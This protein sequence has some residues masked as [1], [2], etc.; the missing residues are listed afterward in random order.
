MLYKSVFKILH[1]YQKKISQ[2]VTMQWIISMSSMTWIS[3]ERVEFTGYRIISLTI[4]SSLI[5][6]VEWA[7]FSY[8][9]MRL[10]WIK[11]TEENEKKIQIWQ[12]L[13]AFHVIQFRTI[14]KFEQVLLAFHVIEFRTTLLI[15]IRWSRC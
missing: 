4:L 7:S 5:Y 13:L 10:L 6:N 14:P 1:S 8:I 9:I 3:N 2:S 15:T 12:V 11:N